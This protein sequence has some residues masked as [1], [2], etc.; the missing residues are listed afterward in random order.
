MKTFKQFLEE[1]DPFDDPHN[2]LSKDPK[3]G[4]YG[5]SSQVN[6]ELPPSASTAISKGEDSATRIND[7]ESRFI[8]LE[9]RLKRLEAMLSAGDTNIS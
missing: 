2:V 9:D 7:L 6:K 4:K 1:L 3:W 8:S 5:Q